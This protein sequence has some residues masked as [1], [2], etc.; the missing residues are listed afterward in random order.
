MS[1]SISSGLTQRLQVRIGSWPARR[2]RGLT[3]VLTLAV[4]SVFVSAF[5]TGGTGRGRSLISF[6][7]KLDGGAQRRR[8]DTCR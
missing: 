6:F 7:Q 2:R 1:A 5:A 4:A 3:S 8:R